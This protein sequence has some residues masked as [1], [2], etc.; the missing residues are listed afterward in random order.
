MECIYNVKSKYGSVF[1]PS[2]EDYYSQPGKL[3]RLMKPEKKK[4]LFENTT[5]AMGDAPEK[6]KIRHLANCMK[7]DPSMERVADGLGIS[8]VDR[9]E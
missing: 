7:A 4:V 5:R 3:F 6:V 8:F 1:F 2:G 9:P